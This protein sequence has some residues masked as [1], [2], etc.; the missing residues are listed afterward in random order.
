MGVKPIGGHSSTRTV[1]RGGRR[2]RNP[3]AK[4]QGDLVARRLKNLEKARKVRMRNVRARRK[5]QRK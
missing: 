2:K 4:A 3:A 1:R 5:A